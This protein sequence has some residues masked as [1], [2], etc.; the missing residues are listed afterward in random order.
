MGAY[1]ADIAGL[2]DTLG[3]CG[4]KRSILQTGVLS[5][6]APPAV[7]LEELAKAGWCTRSEGKY[8]FRHHPRKA[9][10]LV[11]SGDCYLKEGLRG[12]TIVRPDFMLHALGF[13]EVYSIDVA[14]HDSPTYLKDL[15]APDTWQQIGRQ[16]DVIVE[17]G[18][19]EHVFHVPNAL[20][21]LVKMCEVGGEILHGAPMN[22]WPNH[23]FYQFSPTLYFD[24]YEAN[25]FEIVDAQV[26]QI[27]SSPPGLRFLSPYTRELTFKSPIPLDGHQ[28]N[29]RCRVRKLEERDEMRIPFQGA[30]SAITTWTPGQAET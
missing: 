17:Y 13:D 29:F 5:L 22:N 12:N 10:A 21:N 20:W 26:L 4:K 11:Q 27:P 30:Y 18:T 25:G 2:I 1:Q 23:G 7:I 16:F 6:F 19:I 8:Y 14:P 3:K 15:N 28:Y 9:A 24:F